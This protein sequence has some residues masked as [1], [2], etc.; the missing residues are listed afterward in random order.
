M[1]FF[2]GSGRCT[3]FAGAKGDSGLMDRTEYFELFTDRLD[4]RFQ[5]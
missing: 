5:Q 4:A 1:H 2:R 3:S